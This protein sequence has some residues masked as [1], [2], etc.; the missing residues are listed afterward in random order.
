MTE[1]EKKKKKEDD[2][3]A[4]VR[5][6]IILGGAVFVFLSIL[7]GFKLLGFFELLK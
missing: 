4:L 2:M 6:L 3:D 5:K 1:D 7:L